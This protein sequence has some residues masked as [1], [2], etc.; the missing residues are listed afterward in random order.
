MRDSVKLNTKLSLLA[1]CEFVHDFQP[2]GNLVEEIRC[3]L[4]G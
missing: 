2:F 4:V 1:V 3:D